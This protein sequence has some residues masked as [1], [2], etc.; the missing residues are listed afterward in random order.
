MSE[1]PSVGSLEGLLRSDLPSSQIKA[2]VAHLLSGCD[3]CRAGLTPLATVMF[4][5]QGGPE[6]V[7]SNEEDAAYDSAISAA[8]AAAL[9]QERLLTSERRAAEAVGVRAGA[10]DENLAVPA[11]W[12]L[13]ETLLEQSWELRDSD[14]PEMLRLAALACQAADELNPAFY[15]AKQLADLQARASADLAN[16]YRLADALAEA[17]EAM[18]RALDLRTQGTGDP[19]LYARI[20]ALRASLLTDQRRFAEAF[21]MLDAARSIYHQYGESHEEGR[22]LITKGLHTGYAGDSEA[23]FQLLC[24]GLS[25]I[26]RKRD[27]KLVL[28]ALHNILLFRVEIGEYEAASRQI[29]QMWPLY[30]AH[31]S[32][33]DR[34]K[35]RWIEGQIAAGLGHLE[36]AEALLLQT[37]QDLDGAGVGYEAALT[38][39]NLAEVWL[40]QGKTAT[41]REMVAELVLTFRSLGV[42]R[43]DLAAVLLLREAVERDEVTLEIL[44]RASGVLRRRPNK[45]AGRAGLDTF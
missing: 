39:L 26:D 36:Q 18:A 13:C 1:H 9:K 35:L 42:E 21:H 11:T 41:V 31:A 28:Q 12:G 44:R 33:I 43:E 23:G 24:Q 17:E 14:R 30:T 29:R 37:K 10:F 20:A 40:R 6:P 4:K 27:G 16:A 45:P 2:T 7:L 34:A 15:G 19:L 38:A 8:F 3:Q 25:M 5:P 22:I 32:W